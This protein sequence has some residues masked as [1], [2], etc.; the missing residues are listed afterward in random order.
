MVEFL[1][2]FVIFPLW[3]YIIARLI[4]FAVYK[5]KRENENKNKNL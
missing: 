1:A 3:I 4:T 2:V 5:S